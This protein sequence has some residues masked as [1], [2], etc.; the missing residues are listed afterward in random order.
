[1]KKDYYEILGLT[2]SDKSLDG[3]E[4]SKVL[5]KAYR[6]LCLK[7]HPDKFTSKSDEEKKQAE[8][9]FKD[10]TEAYSVLSDAEKRKKYDMFGT[11]DGN[12]FYSDGGDSDIDEILRHFAKTANPFNNPFGN[13]H[14]RSH[15]TK[16]RGSDKRLKINITLKELYEGGNKEIKFKLKRPCSHCNGSGLGKYG[17]VSDCPYCGG[18]GLKV[19]RRIHSGGYF[20]SRQICPH[21]GGTGKTVVNG[22]THCGGTGVVDD[23]VTMNIK[24]PFISDCDKEYVKRGGGNVGNH[25]GTCGDLYLS[26]EVSN[27]VDN[28]YLSNSSPFDIVKHEK[29]RL[30]DCLLGNDIKVTHINGK[31][32]NC[33]IDSC[34]PNDSFITIKGEGLP[35]PDGTRGD[36][37]IVVKQLFPT[38]LSNDDIKIL[39][40]LKKSVNFK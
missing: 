21:C 20:E 11:V 23:I 17:K 25:N 2:D 27:D 5:K 7:Y 13:S 8:D 14:S 18:S 40:K 19:E 37:K 1:M 10:I 16:Q 26:Y 22:C 24:I 6:K 34:T 39:N 36:L 15:H 35:K 9:K 32:I 3:N 4:F 28:F 38:T 33:H 31:E 29:I 30:I 12:G